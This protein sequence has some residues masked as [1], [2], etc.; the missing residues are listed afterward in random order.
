ML[1]PANWRKRKKGSRA[2]TRTT[3]A[4]LMGITA[5]IAETRGVTAVEFALVA[6][7]L[8]ATILFIM[9]IGYMLF[10][11]ESLD[12]ATQKAARLIKTGQVQAAGLTQ[13]QFVA[14][15]I[16]PLLT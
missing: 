1:Y 12:Y 5:F 9:S 15:D 2:R 11:S 6:P 8:L 10:M 14:Q 16:C 7:L 4:P 3:P 13:A